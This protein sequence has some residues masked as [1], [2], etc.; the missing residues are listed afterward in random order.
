MKRPGSQ[1]IFLVAFFKA[2]TTEMAGYWS[3]GRSF[4]QLLQK[5]RCLVVDSDVRLHA[6]VRVSLDMNYFR[7]A[8]IWD[9]VLNGLPAQG[10]LL[11]DS[12]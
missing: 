2:D 6:H 1:E 8:R 11:G 10:K 3:D 5:V 12:S 9:R 4:G 7:S